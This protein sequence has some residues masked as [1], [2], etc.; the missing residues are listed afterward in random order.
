LF[1]IPLLAKGSSARTGGGIEIE[2]PRD[3]LVSCAAEERQWE[4]AGQG[5]KKL[6]IEKLVGAL[7]VARNYTASASISEMK[8]NYT[9]D[10][11]GDSNSTP[12]IFLRWI[13]SW[14]NVSKGSYDRSNAERHLKLRN[15]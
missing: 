13:D 2:R 4:S 12:W 10:S 1:H 6:K 7:P 15:Q 14:N 3:R 9:F 11:L 8:G 5:G